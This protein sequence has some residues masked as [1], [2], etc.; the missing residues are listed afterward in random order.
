MQQLTGSTGS[1]P[2]QDGSV[3]GIIFTALGALLTFTADKTGWLTDSDIVTL[4]PV[5]I[6][7]SFFL[8]GVFDKYFRPSS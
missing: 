4:G 5:L 2:I 8:G 6:G 7:L 3:R 1:N